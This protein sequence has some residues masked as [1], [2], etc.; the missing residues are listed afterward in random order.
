MYG[1]SHIS[2]VMRDN[3]AKTSFASRYSKSTSLPRTLIS[4]SQEL[5]S[6][7]AAPVVDESGDQLLKNARVYMLAVKLGLP[8]LKSLALSKIHCVDST[9]KGKIAYARY[10]YTHTLNDNTSIRAPVN[11]FCATESH[12]LLSEAEESL[13]ECTW[14]PRNPGMIFL[15]RIS[16]FS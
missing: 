11:N 5:E 13:R 9:A 7:P 14:N 16:C 4:G 6:D 10:V 2:S 3:L 1:L 12:T 15:V 8:S